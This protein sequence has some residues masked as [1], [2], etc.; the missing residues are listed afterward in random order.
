MS[1]LEGDEEEAAALFVEKNRRL[2]E[3]IDFSKSNSVQRSLSREMYDLILHYLGVRKLEKHSLTVLEHRPE[4]E[5]TW[6]ISRDKFESAPNRRYATGETGTAKVVDVSIEQL[7]ADLPSPCT[8]ADLP[9]EAKGDVAWIF[10]YFDELSDFECVVTPGG[11]SV[12]LVKE[13]SE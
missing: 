5:T 8:L 3:T 7:Y 2:L 13:S 1:Y 6:V 10:A 11:G 9:N 12:E 4:D